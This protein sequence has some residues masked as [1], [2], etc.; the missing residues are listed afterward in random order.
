M[1]EFVS[2]IVVS[3]DDVGIPPTQM[4]FNKSLIVQ[5]NEVKDRADLT[6]LFVFNRVTKEHTAFEVLA[7]F[8]IV[9]SK[10]ITKQSSFEK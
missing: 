8:K 5:A 4:L 7:D 9:E 3:S 10:L 1:S 2:F 6:T